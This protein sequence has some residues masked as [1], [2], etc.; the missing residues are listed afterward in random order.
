MQSCA[1]DVTALVD[2]L[3]FCLVL[4]RGYFNLSIAG[5]RRHPKVNSVYFRPVFHPTVNSLESYFEIASIIPNLFLTS[6][7]ELIKAVSLG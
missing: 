3:R 6:I 1:T 7:V 4:A 2:F 5:L